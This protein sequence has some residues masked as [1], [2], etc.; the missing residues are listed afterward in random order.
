MQ[1]HHIGIATNNINEALIKIR[2]YIDIIEISDI[3][4]DAKQD[5]DLCMLTLSSGD[6]ME[7]VSG[8]IVENIVKKRQYLYHTCYTVTNLAETVKNLVDDGA[9]LVKEPTEAILFENKKVAFLSWDLG[10]IELLE[11]DE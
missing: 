5:A 7:L 6:R 11:G 4:H 2:K 9:Y 1:F 10:L 3:V 8:K